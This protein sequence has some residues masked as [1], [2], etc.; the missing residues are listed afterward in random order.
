M[1]VA[2]VATFAGPSAS[3]LTPAPFGGIGR[4]VV[5]FRGWLLV[6]RR[7]RVRARIWCEL[8]WLEDSGRPLIRP[9][10]GH[11]LQTDS[12]LGEKE[13]RVRL[14]HAPRGGAAVLFH[15]LDGLAPVLFDEGEARV[16]WW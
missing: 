12:Q 4:G 15:P 7:L 5:A 8:D 3:L 16:L 9:L 6:T 14:H 11:L 13:G 10:R 2:A 1:A